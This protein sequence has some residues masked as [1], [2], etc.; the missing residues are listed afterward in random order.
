VRVL[1]PT[2]GFTPGRLEHPAQDELR[3]PIRRRRR[4]RRSDSKRACRNKK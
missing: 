3:L 1:L 2:E 4:Q